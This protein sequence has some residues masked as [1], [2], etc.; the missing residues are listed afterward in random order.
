MPSRVWCLVVLVVPS[1]GA[2]WMDCAASEG[3]TSP[4][5]RFSNV[6]SD[7]EIVVKGGHQDIYKVITN[8][9]STQIV[10]ITAELSQYW[11]AFNLTW[12]RFL[13][14]STN[15][16]AEHGGLCPLAPKQSASLVTHHPK[17]AWGTPY[18]WYRSKQVYFDSATGARIGCVDMRFEYCKTADSCR[19]EQERADEER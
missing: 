6:T 19:Y 8:V 7:P 10:N 18:G 9:G 4:A 3:I 17:L 13:K 2:Y 15:A 1:A 11:K 14:I 16:C 12:V 5:L